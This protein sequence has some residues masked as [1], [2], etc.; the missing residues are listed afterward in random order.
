MCP[1]LLRQNEVPAPFRDA[2]ID[3]LTELVQGYQF[4][5]DV[6]AAQSDIARATRE[7]LAW[8]ASDR[9]LAKAENESDE[10]FR[11][12]IFAVGQN[13]TEEA[14]ARGVNAILSP[15]TNLQCEINDAALDRWFLGDGTSNF[16]WHSYL[17][18]GPSYPHRYFSDDVEQNDGYYR[19]SSAVGGAR[20]YDD[21]YG[22][23]LLVRVPDLGALDERAAFVFGDD[24]TI[25]DRAT[26][27]FFLGDGTD[28]AVA[29]FLNDV[30]LAP[31]TVYRAIIAF[32]NG[33]IGQSV[34]WT[35]VADV[36]VVN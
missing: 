2:L 25:A 35:M 5:S 17:G 3:A 30:Q 4:R 15:F 22:R 34:R 24:S 11:A 14:I 7:Y 16:A 13:V 28:S 27:G 1:E 18:A 12:R 23:H 20:L 9:Q 10:T 29:A 36:G 32:V 8:L 6:A 33:V 19:P 26:T 21:S 31:E